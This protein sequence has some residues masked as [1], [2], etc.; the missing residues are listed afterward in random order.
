MTPRWY[1]D[2][3]SPFSYLHWQKMRPLVAA[4]RAEAVPV[5]LGAL[6][7]AR[8]LAGPAEIPGKREFIY[9]QA[10]W[11]ARQEG[12]PLVFPPAHP[13]NPLPA[14]R[15]CVAAGTTGE[16]IEAVFAALWR[17]GRDG[18]PASL[19]A[20][21]RGLGIDDLDAATADPGVRQRL[22]ANTTMALDAGV[23]GVPT[24]EL[25]GGLFWGN[26]SHGL[27]MAA[28]EDPGLL[29]EGPLAEI[30]RLPVGIS[31]RAAP[32]LPAVAAGPFP[33]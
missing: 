24:L 1:F 33:R 11:Q 14:L 26:D 32:P 15:L 21:A 20:V 5:V 29:R 6:L 18:S 25:D 8:N 31:R 16:A 13:F 7:S 3:V 22:R 4:G 19:A 12:V 2:F 30:G 9:R 23:F 27:M 10:L 17:E 28:L